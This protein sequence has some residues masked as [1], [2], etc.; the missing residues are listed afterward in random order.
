[1]YDRYHLGFIP[2]KLCNAIIRGFLLPTWTIRTLKQAYVKPAKKVDLMVSNHK[3][4][5][6]VYSGLAVSAFFAV[7]RYFLQM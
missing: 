4:A 5:D 6:P 3:N 7:R 1:M 2:A